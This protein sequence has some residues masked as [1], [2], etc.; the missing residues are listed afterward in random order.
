MMLGD[1]LLLVM[2]MAQE[3]LLA[4]GTDKVLHVP[5]FPQGGNDALLNGSPAGT[6]DGDA[7]LVVAL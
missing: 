5:V 7:H 2:T 6:T 1:Y 3:G 4:F